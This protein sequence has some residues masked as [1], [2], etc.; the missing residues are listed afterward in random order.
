MTRFKSALRSS[1]VGARSSPPGRIVPCPPAHS[2]R[3]ARRIALKFQR[4][5]GK[6]SRPKAVVHQIHF[7]AAPLHGDAG[8]LGWQ[9]GWRYEARA[10]CAGGPAILC[11]SRGKAIIASVFLGVSAVAVVAGAAALRSTAA[12]R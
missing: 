4:R 11:V 5:I 12:Q 1:A 3:P 10:G 2:A 6:P 7:N 9:T 8:V